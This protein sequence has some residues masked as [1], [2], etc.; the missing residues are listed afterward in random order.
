MNDQQL[1]ASVVN[2]VKKAVVGKDEALIK[3][4]LAVLSRGHGVPEGRGPVQPLP[5]R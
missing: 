5:G 3:V 1:A 2:E 4:L